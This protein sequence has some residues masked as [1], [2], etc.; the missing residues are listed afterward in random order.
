[1]KKF[2]LLFLLSLFLF[3]YSASAETLFSDIDETHIYFSSIEYLE[4]NDYVN[5]YDDGTFRPDNKIN[6]AEFLKIVM[7]GVNYSV[8]GDNCF[9]DVN[10]E[11]FA[12]YVCEAKELGIIDGYDDGTFK[13]SQNISFVEAS[14]IIAEALNYYIDDSYDD[15]WYQKYVMALSGSEA[16][17]STIKSFDYEITRG[18]MARIIHGSQWGS[19]FL[20]DIDYEILAGLS[21]ISGDS[22]KLSYLLENRFGVS[23]LSSDILDDIDYGSF[24][25]LAL[26]TSA[27]GNATVCEKVTP[28]LYRDKDAIYYLTPTDLGSELKILEGADLETFS[29]VEDIMYEYAIDK[30]HLYENV[31]GEYKAVLDFGEDVEMIADK[32]FIMDNELYLLGLNPAEF[33][34]VEGVDL[35]TFEEMDTVVSGLYRDKDYIYVYDEYSVVRLETID[36]ESFEMLYPMQDEYMSDFYIFKDKNSIY[37]SQYDLDDIEVLDGADPESFELI[38]FGDYV[39]DNIGFSIGLFAKDDN[40]LYKINSSDDVIVNTEIDRDNF[41]FVLPENDEYEYYDL[42][43]HIKDENG[44]YR[45]SDLEKLDFA[46]PND[47]NVYFEVVG[48]FMDEVYFVYGD[49]NGTFWYYNEEEVVVDDIDPETFEILSEQ[50]FLVDDEYYANGF[51]AKDENNVWLFDDSSSELVK[52][53]G[54]DAETFGSYMEDTILFEDKDNIYYLENFELVVLEKADPETFDVVIFKGE[55]YLR[56]KDY[57]WT[58]FGISDEPEIMEGVD[59]DEFFDR[60]LDE[61]G[62][63]FI[64]TFLD[65]YNFEYEAVLLDFSENSYE[66]VDD[67]SSEDEILAS[68]ADIWLEPGDPEFASINAIIGYTDIDFDEITLEGIKD[69]SFDIDE[70]DSVHFDLKEPFLVDDGENI[71]KARILEYYFDTNE[72]VLEYVILE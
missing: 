40:A 31:D 62:T 33:Y 47:F 41:E 5:G 3:S 69:V 57:V 19:Y 54:V 29:I 59:P 13:P 6:R 28:E 27:C 36:P 51:I 66:G 4:N 46:D 1:M 35:D 20:D 52:I 53:E 23:S 56:D 26:G 22:E 72:I 24:R 25:Q 15:N 44:V 16:I 43:H 58:L 42:F 49:S 65:V 70:L 50:S 18:E 63:Y 61:D 68:G 34:L 38:D 30:N 39:G 60:G 11:W 2:F 9:E 32:L 8:S 14:K 17:P 12:P 10:D 71:Y 21:S 48:F 7:S 45:L 64:V 55:G 37:F 67:Y